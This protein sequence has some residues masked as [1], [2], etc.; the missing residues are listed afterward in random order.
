MTG[1]TGG[2]GR[3]TVQVR[4]QA[5]YIDLD[6]CIACGLCAEKCP[7][8]VPDEFNGGLAVRKAV[9]LL[10]PQGVP[11]K[12][13]INPDDCL[14]FLTGK[15]RACAEVCPTGAVDLSQASQVREIRVGAVILA[16]GFKTFDPSPYQTYYYASF[17]NVI[18][19]LEFER[20]L[21]ASGP[22]AGHLMRPS[23]HKE[24]KKMAW[25]QCVGSRD[26]HRV[27]HRYCSA[28]CC[29]Y[30]I[31]QAVLAREHSQDP[32]DTAIFYL[33][34]RTPGKDFEKYYQRAAEGGVRFIR[35]R[36]HSIE[37]KPGTQDLALRYVAEDGRVE[38]E[39]FDLVV[40]SVGLE[41][42]PEARRS[43]QLLGVNLKPD[44]GF[45]DTTPF[46]PVN[47]SRPG[48]FV[49]GAFQG[50]KD[51]PQAVME[52]SA[53]AAAASELLASARHSLS[54]QKPE[55]IERDISQE[56]P[57]IG[58]LLCHCGSNIAG[59]IDVA[60][61][62][63]YAATLPYVAYAQDYSFACSQDSQRITV[64]RIQEHGLNRVVVA[65]CSPRTHE[66]VFQ[67]NLKEA[68]LNP[69]L[70][71]MANIRDQDAWVHQ[72]EPA[73]ALEKA[74]DLV[75]MAV[76]RATNLD[77]LHK[78]KFP[79]TRA[80]LILGG[81]VAGMEASRS[82]AHMGF[83]TY[84]VEKSDRLG[85]NARNLAVS[86]RGYDYQGYLEELIQA[87]GDH[88]FIDI[89]LNSQAKQAGGFI[90]N[91][92]TII[93]TPEG[94]R[95]LEH[96]VTILATGGAPLVP[97]EYL[98][99][100]H[101]NVLL[102][103]ELDKA[104]ISQDPRLIN[105]RQAVFIQCVGSREPERPYCSK[106]CCTHSVENSLVLKELNPEMDVFVLYR[107]LRT[108][109][110]KELLYQKARENG[111]MFI[112]YDLDNKPRVA[113]T[114]EGDLEVTVR[115]PILGR[116]LV[117]KPDLLTLASAILPNP[118]TELVELFKVPCNSEGFFNEAHAKLRP[119]E[120]VAE[121]IYLAGLAH[122]P[123]P[124]DESIAQ[125]KAAA[126]R[127]ATVLALEEVAVEPLVARVD[128]D[129]CLGCGLCEITCPFG[130]M[131]LAKVPGKGFRAENLPAYCK[132]CGLC[133]AGCPVRAIDMQHFRDRQILE[134]I[135][136]GG[137][138]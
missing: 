4:Q 118:T 64:G 17:P 69:Y 51:I 89:M 128:Q 100:Q 124:L 84:L 11:L 56:E 40:L 3:F 68:G 47:T 75:R 36:V 19:S 115:D 125:A 104:I 102:S 14:H 12:Y 86:S 78:L 129:L 110:D 33:D 97:Q 7:I 98:Y 127:A 34:L 138:G 126:S 80:A 45:A 66:A 50:P 32:L 42:S 10:Y 27:D 1:I 49:C 105:A 122:Y 58:V 63:D 81:G 106:V 107:D 21:S 43:A 77:P 101:P 18:T 103:L 53:A 132:G 16:P 30:A 112:R 44:M 67:E 70:L 108:Y 93:A 99:G 38:K 92:R 111:V 85:G 79:V 48:I 137:R 83:Q 39:T 76:A 116:S 35:S 23:D 117:L 25:L 20:L 60:A 28:V 61:L 71:E 131:R 52:A 130:A 6:K 59:V 109:G 55:G 133:A 46:A 96:G 37:Q 72:H 87:V 134:A 120:C 57:R 113:T 119:V 29:M 135:Q 2:A 74:K 91:F 9:Y 88:P 62:R 54:R 82:L 123:K 8:H 114:P 73:A 13:A 95:E 26:Y 15:C 121:G 90:G 94:D 22:F 31:K 5:R 41:A 24:P 136:V 65:S